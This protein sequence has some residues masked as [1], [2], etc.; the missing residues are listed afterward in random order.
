VIIS[1]LIILII[2]S[3]GSTWWLSR[4]AA[5]DTRERW[6]SQATADD[7]RIL[8][9]AI[10]DVSWQVKNSDRELQLTSTIDSPALEWYLRDFDQLKFVS[11]IPKDLTSDA[12]LTRADLEPILEQSYVGSKFSYLR[13]DTTHVLDLGQALRWWL[14]HQSPVSINQE[15]LIFWVRADLLGVTD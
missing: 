4:S 3:W 5:N 9:E 12:L 2:V 8:E 15:Q 14:F 1:S 10:R 6:V 11:T 13:P 7:I